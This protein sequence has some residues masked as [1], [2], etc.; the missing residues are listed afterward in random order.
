MPSQY[1]PRYDENAIDFDGLAQ[2]YG[3]GGRRESRRTGRSRSSLYMRAPVNDQ[4]H[5]GGAYDYNP[6]PEEV[7]T[8]FNQ[9][10]EAQQPLPDDNFNNYQQ[11]YDY[12]GE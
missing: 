12:Q 2:N 3:G 10:Y 8:D 9:I 6:A 11:H 7:Y 4:A 1:V 5:F